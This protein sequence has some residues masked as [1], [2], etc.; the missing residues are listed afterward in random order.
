MRFERY[1]LD[2]K[3]AKKI[4]WDVRA[5]ISKEVYEDLDIKKAKKVIYKIV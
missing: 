4:V 2:M 5:K 3:E 1:K